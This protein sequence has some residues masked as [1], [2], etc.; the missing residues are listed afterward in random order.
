MTRWWVLCVLASLA[1]NAAAE[2]PCARQ[3]LSNLAR[4][5][6]RRPVA[7][8]D[9]ETLLTF[10]QSARNKKNFEAGIQNAL[11]LILTNPKFLFRAAAGK[12]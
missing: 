7:A 4:R 5:A 11:R 6:Y 12:L 2:L 8:G 10:Y 3:I 9:L 1:A